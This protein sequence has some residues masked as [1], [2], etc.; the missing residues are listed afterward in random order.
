MPFELMILYNIFC[1]T[2]LWIHHWHHR[3][4]SNDRLQGH[5]VHGIGHRSWLPQQA[6]HWFLLSFGKLWWDFS[7]RLWYTYA[8]W[9][10][11][12]QQVQLLCWNDC[13]SQSHFLVLQYLLHSGQMGATEIS[14][15]SYFFFLGF[16]WCAL[17]FPLGHA[18]VLWWKWAY[19]WFQKF[20]C[21]NSLDTRNFLS[22][23]KLLHWVLIH[24]ICC[25][26]RFFLW[27]VW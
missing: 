14:Q 20:S 6:L 26:S 25:C 13:F 11:L 5:T 27:V 23:F 3:L 2:T 24:L 1:S 7:P 9:Q 17:H 10:V 19:G 22:P 8:W 15:S 18:S 21:W 12:L 4:P 16:P